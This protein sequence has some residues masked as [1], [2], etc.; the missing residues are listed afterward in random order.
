MNLYLERH[1]HTSAWASRLLLIIL[2]FLISI[3]GMK[4]QTIVVAPEMT[5]KKAFEQIEQQTGMS[6]D[7]DES[8]LD[9]DQ[10]IHTGLKGD[11][12]DVLSRLLQGTDCRYVI[13]NRHIIISV[14]EEEAKPQKTIR[15]TGNIIDENDEPLIGVNI[16]EKGTG[17][18]TI[19]DPNGYFTL[20]VNP[21][22]IIEITYIGYISQ[23]IRV[24]G[25]TSLHIRMKENTQNINE[26]IVIAYG[27]TNKKD[28]TGAISTVNPKDMT[29][30]ST[31]SVSR[32][33]EGAVSGLQVSAVDG[34]SGFDMGIRVRG[35]GSANQNSSA[36]L[37][38][39]DGV[40]AQTE[41]PLSMISPNDIDNISIL[42]DAAS[43]A[44]YGSRGANGVVMITTKKG[45]KG[46]AHISVDMRWGINQLGPSRYNKIVDPKDYYEFAWQAIYNSVRYGVNGTGTAQ[47]YTTNLLNPN[48]SHEAAAEFASAHLFNYIGSE[49]RF[50]RNALG[51]WMLYDVPGAVYLPTGKGST[52]SATM[53][54]AYLVGT[55]GRLNPDARLLYEG[56]NY[57]DLLKNSLRQEYNVSANGGSERMDYFV[58]LGYLEDPSYIKS[59]LFSRYNGRVNLNAYITD[60]LRIGINGAYAYSKR[61]QPA[62]RYGRNPGNV[63]ANPFIFINAQNPLYQLYARDKEG[64]FIYKDGKK[65]THVEEGD[66]YSPLGPTQAAREMT[67]ALLVQDLDKY[68]TTT[69]L[70][71]TRMFAEIRFLNHFTLT[72]NMAIDKN[73]DS[74]LRYW[75][76]VTGQSKGTGAI[77]KVKSS[78]SIFNA[79]QLLNYSRNFDKHHT[80]W[81][82]GHEYN[83]YHYEMMR[84][85]SSYE[86]IPGYPAWNNFTGKDVGGTFGSNGTNE[87]I[88]RM[89]SY[90]LRGNY[91]YDE[92]YYATVSLRIDGSSKFK[93]KR[94][95]WGTFW[96]VGGG[97]RLIKE[98]FM[99]GTREWLDNLKIRASYG[100][101]GNQNGISNYSGYQ[102]WL[103]TATYTPS[104]SG[105]G[106][107]ANFKLIKGNYVNENLT[108]EKSLTFDAGIDFS[109]LN[110]FSGTIDFYNRT[111]TNVIWSQPIDYAKGQSSLV[112]NSAAMRNRGIEVEL[113]VDL[114]KNRDFNWGV[115]L[116]GTHFTSVLTKAPPGVGSKELNGN[117]TAGALG[118]ATG[119]TSD[120]DDRSNI[121]YLRGVGK[122]YFNLYFYK[123]GGVDPNT[124]LP[125]FYHR[126]TEADHKNGLF[127]DTSIG[128]SVKTTDY[129]KASRYECGSAIPKWIGGFSTDV[130]YKNIDFMAVFTGQIGGKFY[131]EEY[132]NNLY[133]AQ[134]LSAISSELLGNTWS[135][136]HTDAKFP[137]VMY[138][139]IHGD[140]SVI[141][142]RYDY[143]DLA[144][145]NASYL[146]VKNITIGYTFPTRILNKLEVSRLRVYASA[147][148]LA[149]ITSHSGIDPRMS[150]SGG[151]E[152]GPGVF[153]TQ[154]TFSLGLTIN[155]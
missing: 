106:T 52:A 99:E 102:T 62:T 68:Q 27:T 56:G 60:W 38:V 155:F 24:N 100:L 21:A 92:T 41:N 26:V 151:M 139:N 138:G 145:F 129:S 136:Q 36:A 143:T 104:T 130:T 149:M 70:L 49:T 111:T 135:P 19:T 108:W 118:F 110:R 5:L 67:D 146:N 69:G 40:P 96:S 53:S 128:E 122:D 15:V 94:N 147:D 82:F 91:I 84:L 87:E 47:N 81:M 140:G 10:R 3:P 101:I 124:G 134:N 2:L 50:Q 71:T 76:S 48:M 54:G 119:G 8:I 30:Q 55:D 132:G 127:T 83:N 153:P 23:N 141:G 148:N 114:F 59:S 79:Q 95:R 116:N 154:R 25:P 34:M 7:Y 51:N 32:A 117:W 14:K 142:E 11:L 152:V 73:E 112:T 63:V 78:Y 150:I 33:L 131:S 43:T 93:Y 22:A 13:R 17:N 16:V 98:D 74:I 18:G 90:F 120:L 12:P 107:P 28:L 31:S 85:R 57:D 103:Y 39:I 115:S 1:L 123:Y 144:L 97:W 126:V 65:V 80:D 105:T 113:N 66:S 45:R 46:K 44:L 86:L 125:L 72:A 77:G 4:G 61:A 20:K 42:K 9:P 109:L 6:V 88:Q 133:I 29:A 37:I 121:T 64:K 75:N 137:M 89:E 35:I 58:S